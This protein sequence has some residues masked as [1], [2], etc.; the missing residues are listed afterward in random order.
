MSIRQMVFK[1]TLV[2]DENK[3]LERANV[4]I[5]FFESEHNSWKTATTARTNQDGEI[6]RR[7]IKNL[8]EAPMIQ[9]KHNNQVI[10]QGGLVSYDSRRR[11]LEIDFG[12]IELLGEEAYSLTASDPDN[13]QKKQIGGLPKR[14][15]VSFKPILGALKEYRRTPFIPTEQLRKDLLTD[16]KRQSADQTNGPVLNTAKYQQLIDSIEI[17]LAQQAISKSALDIQVSQLRSAVDAKNIQINEQR[18]QFERKQAELESQKASEIS[19]INT[20]FES[21]INNLSQRTRELENQLESETDITSLQQ[22]ISSGLENFSK[23]Q[24]QAGSHFRLGRVQINVKGLFSGSGNRM[25]LADS[26]LL[27]DATNAAALSEMVVEYIPEPTEQET[28]NTKVPDLSGLSESAATRLLK[29]LGFGIEVAYGDP[30][31]PDITGAGQAFKQSPSA[32]E[33]L[34]KGRKVLVIFAH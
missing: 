34:A 13:T 25:T 7:V 17:D 3:P 4:Q 23:E 29:A 21:I 10:S 26:R 27:K 12:V 22:S 20:N 9:L 5:Q 11:T 2:S 24:A 31:D 18:I 8:A 28:T 16:E 1:A 33:T 19:K 15:S 32:D 14:Q 6:N 30:P